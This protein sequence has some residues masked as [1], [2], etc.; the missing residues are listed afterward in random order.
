MWRPG[1]IL[2]GIA[3]PLVWISFI[4]FYFTDMNLDIHCSL[5]QLGDSGNLNQFY[6]DKT[7]PDGSKIDDPSEYFL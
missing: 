6:D 5:A 2:Y 1:I 7:K 4:L 3:I